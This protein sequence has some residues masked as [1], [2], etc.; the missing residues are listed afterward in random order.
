[1]IDLLETANA[2]VP[3]PRFQSKIQKTE[4][5]WLWTASFNKGGGYGQIAVGSRSDGTRRMAHAHR[6]T[7]AHVYRVDPGELCVLHRCDTPAC[8]NPDHLFLGTKADNNAD[9]AAKGR[10][11]V[12]EDHPHSVLTAAQVLKIFNAPHDYGAVGR[13][14][15][16]YGVRPAAIFKIRSGENW[17]HV[18]GAGR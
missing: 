10:S 14:A 17:S 7:Y 8:V 18:T 1:M 15:K 5:C 6:L 12:G 9:R 3:S 11:A 2:V 16:K 4:T 13:L